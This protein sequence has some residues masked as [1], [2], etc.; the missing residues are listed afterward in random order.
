MLIPNVW[1]T[2]L[3]VKSLFNKDIQVLKVDNSAEDR[4]VHRSPRDF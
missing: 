2:Y 4:M 1:F 3:S